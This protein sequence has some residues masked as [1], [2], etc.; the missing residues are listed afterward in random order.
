M[1][2]YEDTG[3]EQIKK[4]CEVLQEKTHGKW[5][6]QELSGQASKFVVTLTTDELV[7]QVNN[8]LFTCDW[9]KC[10]F[11]SVLFPG[12][13]GTRCPW[14]SNKREQPFF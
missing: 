12:K 8:A 5:K 2:D 4:A 3:Q 11:C 9:G 14:C 7:R 10:S 6:F 1:E 13:P